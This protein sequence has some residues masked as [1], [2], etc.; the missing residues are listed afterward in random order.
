MNTK[1]NSRKTFTEWELQ[2]LK[3]WLRAEPF[4]LSQLGEGFVSLDM[5]LTES[6]D[7]TERKQAYELTDRL[8]NR[9]SNLLSDRSRAREL[10]PSMLVQIFGALTT[11]LA[12]AGPYRFETNK[13][14]A[15]KI[16][17]S[18]LN[19][20]RDIRQKA[21][22]VAKIYF[23]RAE[24]SLLGEA[25]EQE[26]N[27]ILDS[28][29]DEG[30]YMPFRV[31]QAAKIAQ[32][33][34]EL[35]I[36]IEEIENS[37]STALLSLIDQIYNLKYPRF[38]TS[39]LRGLWQVDFTDKKV[40]HTV[41]AI[42]DYMKAH[43]IPSYVRP[44]AEDLAGKWVVIGYD[45]RRN[46]RRVASWAAQV[47]LY[48]GFK[49]Y[50]ASRATPTPVGIYQAI[51]VLGED[52][53]A[54]II[55]CTASHNPPEWQG[56]KFNPSGG[57][58]APTHLTDIIAARANHKQLLNAPLQ[59]FDLEEAAETGQY[60]E[61][62]PIV[63]YCEWI[64]ASGQKD[65]RI[66]IN[67][68]A[69]RS[70]F[71]DKLVIIDEMHGAG[72]GY[73]GRILGELGVPHQVIHAE[74]DE[75][76]GELEYANPELPYIQPLI[77]AVK[78]RGAVLGL[79]LDTDADRFGIIGEGGEYFRPNQILAMLTKYLGVDRKLT[80][81]IVITQTGLPMIDKIAAQISN[82]DAHK[83]DPNVIPAYVDHAFYV[84]SIG[85]P[86]KTM[87]SLYRNVFVVPVGI[88][89]IADVPRQRNDYSAMSEDEI[90]PDWMNKLLLGGEESSGLT[91]RGHVP[92]KD[93]VWADLLV[94]DMIAY[95]K[96]PLAE[97]WQD[98]T[99][100][101]GCWQTFGSR[102]D[103]DASDEAKEKLIS[104]YLDAFKGARPGEIE[105]AGYKID[106]LGGVRFDLTEIFLKDQNGGDHFLRVRASGTE[107]INRIYYESSDKDGALRLRDVALKKLD[108]FSIEV[109]KSAYSVWRLVDILAFTEPSARLQEAVEQVMASNKWDVHDLI[110]KLRKRL[111]TVEE[112]NVHVVNKWLAWLIKS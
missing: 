9:L 22:E 17:K 96:K 73:L 56:I 14:E 85:Q 58:P 74:T 89:Y 82:N 78:E 23:G 99:H 62:D 95:H 108:D 27:P 102:T 63:R 55:T 45:T 92:D 60:V 94:M 77:D 51:K 33:L 11:L 70:Y 71:S 107:P 86:E 16:A 109:I 12:E 25:I 79:G 84:G 40:N 48:N 34:Y 105:L 2:D 90:G 8:L 104:Y 72:R 43:N 112:R 100:M 67:L 93:G 110:D 15:D 31:I 24:F 3:E 80:G 39:G 98:I 65:Q 47:C 37:D 88:K 36:R 81:R 20:M 75:G 52:N 41:Q 57:F 68:E 111:K 44:K 4:D 106:Y 35:K 87:N 76:L 46:A 30:R 83:P 97:I 50:F 6:Q 103:I 5:W 66:R 91:S 69:I 38:G 10:S 1:I 101:E 18:I 54:G 21:V 42:C 53:I 64:K 59:E 28:M 29:L 32:R 61:F 7:E 13:A 26:I 49:V 19:P